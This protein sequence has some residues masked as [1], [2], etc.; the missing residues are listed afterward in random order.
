MKITIM[1]FSVP[2]VVGGVE[3]V[4][5]HHAR[6]MVQ[7]GHEVKLLAG[8]GETWDIRIPVEVLPLIDSRHAQVLKIKKS[9]D[10]GL[11]PEQ[12][13]ELVSKIRAELD[14]ALRDSDVVIAHNIAS[15]HKNLALTA[16]LHEFHLACS[17]RPRLILWHH[18]LA[19]GA[20]RYENE[21]HPGY[22]WELLR[23][24]WPK[25][26]Q[27]TISEA[28]R[29][30]FAD[31]LDIPPAA[32]QVVPAGIDLPSFLYLQPRTAAIMQSIHLEQAAPILLSPVRLTRR[33]NLE[34]SLSVLA[35]LLH[36]MPQAALVITGPPGAHNPTNIEYM[37]QLQKQRGD[38]GLE[39]RVHI[40]AEY[41]PEGLSDACVADFYRMAD[42]LFLPS[43]EE[44]FGIPILEAAL[45][46]LPIFCS[47]LDP[48]RALAG[49]WADY[50]TPDDKP[51]K[52]AGMIFQRLKEDPVFRLR[53]QIRQSY[54]WEAV[55]RRQIAPLLDS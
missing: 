7:A 49:D 55:F 28:R 10:A 51:S 50:F 36:K 39:G 16:A 48:L 34:L 11:V 23:K 26:K 47:D 41:V 42:A 8:R 40:L 54:S 19:W 32:I 45:A 35:V 2:P 44:G 30:E 12:F 6:Q 33:K 38:L 18:D 43:R 13:H 22:P 1:H 3:S 9:L 52:I 46:R 53:V 21:L 20:A 15:L 27:V 4:I 29:Q 24:P 5:A 37:R 31:L 17:G 14:D 25:V